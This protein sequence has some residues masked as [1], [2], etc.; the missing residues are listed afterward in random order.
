MTEP[1]TLDVAMKS[2]AGTKPAATSTP[3]KPVDKAA[4]KLPDTDPTT[5]TPPVPGSRTLIGWL[6]KSVTKKQLT[7]GVAAVCSLAAGIAAVRLISPGD[8]EKPPTAS[9]IQ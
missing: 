3:P 5:A 7:V 8:P 6:A 9:V 2:L 4:A 1:T